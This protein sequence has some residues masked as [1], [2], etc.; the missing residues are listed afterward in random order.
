[1][2]KTFFFTKGYMNKERLATTALCFKAFIRDY[3]WYF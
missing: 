2:F 1:M 3:L